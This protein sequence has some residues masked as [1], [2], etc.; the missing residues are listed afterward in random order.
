MDN[1]QDTTN[2]NATNITPGGDNKPMGGSQPTVELQPTLAAPQETAPVQATATPGTENA[3]HTHKHSKTLLLAVVGVVLVLLGALF[4]VYTMPSK[5]RAGVNQK[6]I[7]PTTAV[8]SPEE[9][10]AEVIDLGDDTAEFQQLEEDLK[11]LE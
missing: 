9:Y 11:D 2:H 10:D 3:S 6:K 5:Q 1:T 4:A 8:L 7:V